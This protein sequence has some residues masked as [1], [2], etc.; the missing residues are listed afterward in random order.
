MLGHTHKGLRRTGFSDTTGITILTP[1]LA[2]LQVE[3]TIPEIRTTFH[4]QTAACAERL[5]DR[6]FEV[7]RFD[8][9]TM[10]STGRTNLIFCGFIET[11]GIWLKV[12]K[13]KFT[14]ATHHITMRTFNGGR[15]KHTFGFTLAT[16]NA[17]ARIKLPDLASSAMDA[18]CAIDKRSKD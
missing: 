2:D 4:A 3:G 1:V 17:L 8:E 6:V 11:G 16:L 10:D 18:G 14:I 9:F 7:R 13:T 5:I 12:P 15:L